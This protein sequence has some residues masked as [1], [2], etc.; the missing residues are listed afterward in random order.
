M[1]ENEIMVKLCTMRIILLYLFLLIFSAVESSSQDT[2]KDFTSDG[3]TLFPDK[4]YMTEQDWCE[5][6][7]DHDVRYWQGGTEKERLIADEL[8]KQCVIEKTKDTLL[9]ETMYRGVR[10]GGSPYFYNWY[11]WGYG[12]AYERKY[13][14]LTED[15]K[16]LVKRKLEKYFADTRS[17]V[18]QP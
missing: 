4:N 15:E 17:R 16:R 8:L 18:C 9:A 3:C 10:L 11:R 14:P 7:F 6:C 13:K 2:L 5:C 12:W 1:S